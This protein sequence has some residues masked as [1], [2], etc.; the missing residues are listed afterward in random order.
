M[1][2]KLGCNIIILYSEPTQIPLKKAHLPPDSLF[3]P[4]NALISPFPTT[5]VTAS[6]ITI[7]TLKF[8]HTLTHA[9]KY[10]YIYTY[11]NIDR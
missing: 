7:D 8:A 3:L 1:N 10:T 4:R 5:R 11:I 2:P 9:H 6:T